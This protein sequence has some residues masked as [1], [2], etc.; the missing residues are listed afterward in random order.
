MTRL[1]NWWWLRRRRR[2]LPFAPNVIDAR[3]WP[4]RTV[5]SQPQFYDQEKP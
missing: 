4:T 1:R 5:K 3:S 2:P